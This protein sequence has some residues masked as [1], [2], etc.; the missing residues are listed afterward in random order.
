MKNA[1]F[2]FLLTL[3]LPASAHASASFSEPLQP[4]EA[5]SLSLGH[6]AGT[7]LVADWT[8]AEGYYLYRDSLRARF[9][10]GTP[11]QMET[12]AGTMEDD[13]NFGPS[14]VYYNRTSATIAGTSGG[15]IE[16]TY[17]G[18]QVNG[19]CYAPERR[20]IDPVTLAMSNPSAQ[21]A[22]GV[23][24][25]TPASP[26]AGGFELAPEENLVESLLGRSGV[27]ATLGMFLLFGVLLAFTP[28]VFPMYPIVASALAREGEALTPGRGFMLTAAYVL[29]LAT[30]FA[31]VGAAAGWSGQNL[32]MYLQST[33]MTGFIA[34]VFVAL[35]LSMFGLF[36]L[37][38][39]SSMTSWIASRTAKSGGSLGAASALGFSSALIVGP[40]VTAPLAGALLYIARTGDTVLGAAA[41]FALGLGK[42]VPLLVMGTIGGRLLPRAGAWMEKVKSGFAVVFLG[43]AIWLATPLMPSSL[44]LVLY[45]VLLFGVASFLFWSEF[46]TSRLHVLARTL[47]SMAFI[48]GAA[49]AVG[50]AAG[51]TDPFKPLAALANS[52]GAPS[53]T[54]E[55]RFATINS[56]EELQ[57]QL[58][59]TERPSLVYFTA[60]WCVTCRSIE[61]SVFSDNG[62]QSALGNMQL[63]KVDVTDFD[64]ERA[65]LMKTLRVAGPPTIL[66]F[67]AGARELTGT[68]LTGNVKIADMMQ[69]TNRA[70][71]L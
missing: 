9:A 3:C 48:W 42:G 32:Q 23:S 38:L 43:T 11:V 68:R 64:G 28:C 51:S 61:R 34:A 65:Q 22:T 13:P 19:I 39:P 63:L 41:L 45:A 62:V 53:T 70:R 21:P 4:D 7:S 24:W 18:C 56:A 10:D 25:S 44:D 57:S 5:F 67:D 50:A 27:T 16:I 60:D 47:A 36:E 12:L 20:L 30:A 29:G 6:G 17:Q 37:Q 31:L 1:I 59:A 15:Q 71:G 40:C 26:A 49:L 55:L 54:S 14:E 35:A 33:W 66:F 58:A 2:G 8:I 52:G 69:S 46:R